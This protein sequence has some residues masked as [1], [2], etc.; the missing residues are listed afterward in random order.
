M[1][2]QQDEVRRYKVEKVENGW[3]LSQDQYPYKQFIANTEEEMLK[4]IKE[5]VK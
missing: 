4:L 1:Q 2:P 3:L 5:N